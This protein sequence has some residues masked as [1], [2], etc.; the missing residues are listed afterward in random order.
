MHLQTHAGHADRVADAFLRI[1]Q[2]VLAWNGVQDLLVGGNG[3]GL[4]RFQHTV[5][6][7]PAHFA[8]ADR[9]DALRVAALHV[10]AGDGGVNR[11]DLAAGHQFGFLDGALDGLHRRF[12]VHHHA[13]L[14][15]A[16]FM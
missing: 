3:H 9:G 4:G 7:A 5:Q 13:A 11:T 8:F 10:V 12:D 16:R 15:A 1:V 2:H 6:I 14:E